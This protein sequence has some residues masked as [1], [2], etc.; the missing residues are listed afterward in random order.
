MEK[1]WRLHN[2]ERGLMLVRLWLILFCI[3]E[4]LYAELPDDFFSKIPSASQKNYIGRILITDRSG[5]IHEGT[6]LYV[7]SALEQFK[8]EKPRCIILELDTPGGELFAAEKISNAIKK[9]DAEEGI[10]VI[11]YVNNWAIS[12]GALL[13]YSCRYI[14]IVDDAAMGAATPIYQENEEMKNAPEKVNS[15]VRAEFANKAALFGRNQDIARAMVDPDVIL[16]KRGKDILPLN[17]SSD[18]QIGTLPDQVLSPKGKLLTLTANELVDLHVA[19]YMISQP[20]EKYAQMSL[21]SIS[22]H[23]MSA[24]EKII[25]FFATPAV[26]SLLL[27]IAM[28][29]FYIEF[30]TP[31]ASIPGLIGCVALFFIF[32]GSFTQEAITLFEPLCL[33]AGISLILVEIFL[34]PTLGILLFV[35]GS[36]ALFGLLGMSIPGFSELPFDKDAVALYG[37]SIIN[38]LGWASGA[39]LLALLA[40]ILLTRFLSTHSLK[41]S[42]IVLSDSIPVPEEKT[43]VDI[44]SEVSVVSP[45]RPSGKIVY[46]GVVF[47]AIS[48]GEF[49]EANEK[50]IVEERR[51]SVLVV[52]KERK[53]HCTVKH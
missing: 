36:L 38:R 6:W 7:K 43:S 26:S 28:V 19:D 35:G 5:G 11:A 25:A 31:G 15:V 53:S 9:F 39:F 18:I 22:T 20:L 49:V 33:L 48:R 24:K 27:F 41:L 4:G 32:L 47:D 21:L 40:I 29:S 44:G 52:G 8:K 30:S 14:I 34:L 45:L 2:F 42:G 46:K 12:A 23:E 16:V 3:A 37:T 50:V 10:P 51:G 17:N 1:P 13:A